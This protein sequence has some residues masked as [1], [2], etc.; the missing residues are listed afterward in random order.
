VPRL[1]GVLDLSY[2]S[3]TPAVHFPYVETIGYVVLTPH[4]AYI[5]LVAEMHTKFLKIPATSED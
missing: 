3:F 1:D 4:I 2:K 5:M